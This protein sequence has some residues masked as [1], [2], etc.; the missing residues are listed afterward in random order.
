MKYLLIVLLGIGL[1]AGAQYLRK[2]E[3]DA[4]KLAI[5]P[6]VH[7]LMDYVLVSAL[8][9]WINGFEIRRAVLLTLAV[10][11][12]DFAWTFYKADKEEWKRTVKGRSEWIPLLAIVAVTVFSS[13]HF[14]FYGMGQDQGV[15]QTE[16]MLLYYGQPMKGIIVD[17]YDELTDEKY[18]QYYKTFISKKAGYDLLKDNTFVPGIN[19]NEISSEVEGNWHGIPTYAAMLGLSAKIFGLP[20]MQVLGTVCL[21]CLL[22]L[23]EFI[24]SAFHVKQGIRALAILLLGLSPEI[25]WIKKSALTEGFL[26]VLI[27]TYL[28]YM[29]AASQKERIQSCLPIVVFSFYHVTV[30]T[31][32]PMFLCIYWLLYIRSKDHVY[33]KCAQIAVAGY[34]TGFFMMWMVQPKYTLL[35][36]RY[37]LRFLS[38]QQ[39]VVIIAIVIAA[40][41]AAYLFTG[42]LRKI[43]AEEKVCISDKWMMGCAKW[44]CA[45]G[46]GWILTSAVVNQYTAVDYKMLTLVCYSVLSGF[47]IVPYILA[48]IFSR[49]YEIS[50]NRLVLLMMFVWCILIYSAVMRRDVQYYYYYARYLMPYLALIVIFFLTL[51]KNIYR[52]A[53]CLVLGCMLLFPYANT[54]RLNQDDSRMD[55][56]MVTEILE[57]ARDASAVLIDVD[58]DTVD[59]SLLLYYPLKSATDAKVYPVLNTVEETL[60][61]IPEKNKTKCV[62]LTKAKKRGDDAWAKLEY[63]KI[64]AFQEDDL[65]HISKWSGLVTDLTK[66]QM[67]V[68]MYKIYGVTKLIESHTEE[69][70]TSGWTSLNTAGFRWMKSNTAIVE[71]Y[72]KPD[73]YLMQIT[74]GD[75][76]PLKKL[77]IDSIETEVYINQI[78]LKKLKFTKDFGK[79]DTIFIPKEYIK[80]GYNEIS[81]RSDTW[82]PAE[83]GSGDKS[84]YGFSVDSIAFTPNENTFLDSKSSGL[85][86]D[87][88]AGVNDAGY[89]WMLGDTAFA[90]CF[91]KEQDYQMQVAAGDAIPF[92]KLEKQE[93]VVEAYLNQQFVQ[94]I[95]FTKDSDSEQQVKIPKEVVKTGRN[96]LMFKSD[97]W[98]PAEYGDSDDSRYGFSVSYIAL[99]PEGSST[100]FAKSEKAFLDGWSE[101]NENGFR[102]MKEDRAA[103]ECNLEQGNYVMELFTGDTVPFHQIAKEEIQVEIY[104][105]GKYLQEIVYAKDQEPDTKKVRI[106]KEYLK[107]GYNK[108]SFKSDLWSPAEYGSDDKNHYGISISRIEFSKEAEN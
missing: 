74:I 47:M 41:I 28:Y 62:Y 30:F 75:A 35:N 13:G 10:C 102:W 55:W 39:L 100:V 36:Y 81:F 58:A 57:N 31:M 25:I 51:E 68:S 72:L 53:V 33:L 99:V 73:D 59:L 6:I 63:R 89:R 106:P 93:I 17:E 40:S 21:V 45:A 88:W 19:E 101:I 107:K 98:S 65:T 44:V 77:S 97:T 96:E 70:F 83:Y 29:T 15:Y 54:L 61:Y 11:F 94:K 85:Y 108:V 66:K 52:Q 64:T 82:S 103:I 104:I 42:I 32:M 76:I 24:L 1:A 18:K 20:H 23:V 22:F 4:D 12:I 48:K 67:L 43:K 95:K 86:G 50:H 34:L 16:A 79:T 5:L 105:N 26:A 92:E 91:L 2:Q 69:F 56:E 9:F 87:G 78:F 60:K 71:C 7:Y 14:E 84:N 37:G 8:L 90:E 80:D 46:I 38:R 27:V 49:K 3:H